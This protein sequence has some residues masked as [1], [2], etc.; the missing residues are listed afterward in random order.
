MIP[1]TVLLE[2]LGYTQTEITSRSL[3][4]PYL[5]TISDQ[6]NLL[7]WAHQVAR[8]PDFFQR[9]ATEIFELVIRS[10][11]P[12]IRIP[13]LYLL[14]HSQCWMLNHIS[15]SKLLQLPS[16]TS[17]TESLLHAW[18]FWNYGDE[19]L[20]MFQIDKVDRSHGLEPATK[21]SSMDSFQHIQHMKCILQ[22]EKI[23]FSAMICS[24]R[25]SSGFRV[26]EKFAAKLGKWVGRGPSTFSLKGPSNLDEELLEY[27]E[28]GDK[29]TM[30]FESFA[31][32]WI[33]CL[34]P[35]HL[36]DVERLDRIMRSLSESRR[37]LALNL[38]RRFADKSRILTILGDAV[39][40]KASRVRREAC[41]IILCEKINSKYIELKLLH[42][43][44]SPRDADDI[45]DAGKALA[46][47]DSL[48][49][50]TVLKEAVL[51]LLDSKW[52]FHRN[53]AVEACFRLHLGLGEGEVMRKL[54]SLLEDEKEYVRISAAVA[55]LQAHS[56]AN[57]VLP[58][59]LK[60]LT[61]GRGNA[62]CDTERISFECIKSLSGLAFNADVVM[63]LMRLTE[64]DHDRWLA[65]A[66][67]LVTWMVESNLS[68]PDELKLLA[69]LV[70]RIK[71]D[72]YA[73]C[74]LIQSILKKALPVR[75]DLLSL[76][77][78]V[79]D[80]HCYRGPYAH[81]R[82]RSLV[83]GDWGDL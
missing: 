33:A 38:Y 81:Y 24:L 53:H 62:L 80:Y 2:E 50:P 32:S 19:E 35:I 51:P 75:A 20:A 79:Y 23:D 55:I 65:A 21:M 71:D 29:P 14:N 40:D 16:P 63:L 42:L 9:S 3:D 49:D 82:L 8:I 36:V 76:Y 37:F 22:D 73:A 83:A 10:D 48:A 25:C 15:K 26:T 43:L 72:H 41:K 44:Q 78:S 12:K 47:I 45:R 67:V 56:T 1:L 30:A 64:F 46:A 31:Y 52:H 57:D 66:Q 34:Q 27:L 69:V 54:Y 77:E 74:G 70:Q 61:C 39:T 17:T 58:L 6:K 11:D 4:R 5:L 18:L 60:G 59:V 7:K 13:L 68:K 28:N